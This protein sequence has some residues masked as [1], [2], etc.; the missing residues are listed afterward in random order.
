M[1]DVIYEQFVPYKRS[2]FGTSYR[3]NSAQLSEG[4]TFAEAMD[5]LMGD[6]DRLKML[7]TSAYEMLSVKTERELINWYIRFYHH[8]SDRVEVVNSLSA[9][10][11]V[12][13]CVS[14]TSYQAHPSL[15]HLDG[16]EARLYN[17][18][19]KI[20]L[21][22]SVYCEG[23]PRQYFFVGEPTDDE[24]AVALRS[25]QQKN[26][27]LTTS[28]SKVELDLVERSLINFDPKRV[29]ICVKCLHENQLNFT[30]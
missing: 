3:W 21:L 6:Y 7:S 14:R 24:V 16:K 13:N 8:S 10:V 12:I 28:D 30:Q 4:V 20:D 25:Q 18:D 15:E 23:E 19:E 9:F 17:L 1:I 5:G 27:V 26:I 2:T 29:K 22:N 11:M